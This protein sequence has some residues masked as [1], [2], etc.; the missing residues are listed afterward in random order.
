MHKVHFLESVHRSLQTSYPYIYH[1]NFSQNFYF[2][3][4]HQRFQKSL[5]GMFTFLRVMCTFE[6]KGLGEWL[7]MVDKNKGWPL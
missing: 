2:L 5:K 7:L 6:L 1:K 4:P 3:T